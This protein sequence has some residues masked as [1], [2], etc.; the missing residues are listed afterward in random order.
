MF[1]MSFRPESYCKI[2]Y[3]LSIWYKFIFI[4]E[5]YKKFSVLRFLKAL[6]NS[7]KIIS[8]NKN[9]IMEKNENF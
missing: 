2:A 4:F 7:Q 8:L 3:K 9:A 1:N 6:I 5:N